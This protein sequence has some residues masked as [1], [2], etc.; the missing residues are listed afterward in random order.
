MTKIYKVT[1]EIMNGA[2]IL[3]PFCI[4]E[5][6]DAERAKDR[7]MQ[8]INRDQEKINRGRSVET[9][10]CGHRKKYSGKR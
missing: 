5:S 8:V 3:H 4:V 2:F 7:A 1:F 6:Q 10:R 9:I